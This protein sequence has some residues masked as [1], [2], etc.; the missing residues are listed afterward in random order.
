MTRAARRL[1]RVEEIFNLTKIDRWFLVQ[2]K[3][4]RGLRGRT[5]GTKI[6][7]IR[8]ITPSPPQLTGGRPL[9]SANSLLKWNS[10]F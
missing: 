5:D 4:N 10:R 6:D 9:L 3:G 2:I 8:G 7:S 1:H